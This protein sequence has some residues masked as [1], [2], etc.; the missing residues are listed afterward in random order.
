MVNVLKYFPTHAQIHVTDKERELLDIKDVSSVLMMDLPL[1]QVFQYALNHLR[2]DEQDEQYEHLEQNEKLIRRRQ[3]LI[4]T[5]SRIKLL[6]QMWQGRQIYAGNDDRHSVKSQMA[7]GEEEENDGGSCADTT[8]TRI[9]THDPWKHLYPSPANASRVQQDEFIS[10]TQTQTQTQTQDLQSQR[11]GQED[12]DPLHHQQLQ[13]DLTS[14]ILPE[15][16]NHPLEIEMEQFEPELWSRIHMRYAPTVGHVQSLFRCLHLSTEATQGR[17]FGYP[18]AEGLSSQDV[19]ES[20]DGIHSQPSLPLP[21]L[22]ILVGCFQGESGVGNDY[23][24]GSRAPHSSTIY[25]LPTL[26]MHTSTAIPLSVLGEAEDEEEEHADTNDEGQ[27]QVLVEIQGEGQVQIIEGTQEED[28]AQVTFGTHGEEQ[29][30]VQAEMQTLVGVQT[31]QEAQAQEPAQQMAPIS[32]L[33]TPS[34][35]PPIS[36]PLSPPTTATVDYG[37]NRE[38]IEYIKAVSQALSEIKDSLDWIERI[39]GKKAELMVF[40]D[41]IDQHQLQQQDVIEG[42]EDLD[43]PSRR[44]LWLQKVV[45]FW[46]DATVT[47]EQEDLYQH[48]VEHH[49]RQ[50]V[51]EETSTETELKT[52]DQSQTVPEGVYRLWIRTDQ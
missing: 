37:I 4:V 32:L 42:N 7:N 1:R 20:S 52:Q 6:E 23:V 14:D 27:E 30:E 40:E 18:S 5:D 47:V 21:T 46:L 41:T 29:T 12:V 26:S 49:S 3:V 22:V 19:E 33:S 44:R 51:T 2:Q 50:E 45:G 17:T 11:Q 31:P 16:D 28:Q 35:S 43:L 38:C 34:S 10:V 9:G 36:P 48:Q 24:V 8:G 39:T 25:A 15:H 13:H